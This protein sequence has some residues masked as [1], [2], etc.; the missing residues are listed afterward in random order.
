MEPILYH[1]S[2]PDLTGCKTVLNQRASSCDARQLVVA[3]AHEHSVVIPIL[4]TGVA[5][6][7]IPLQNGLLFY[8]L[9]HSGHERVK[10]RYSD[11]CDKSKPHLFFFTSSPPTSI[12]FSRSTSI[13]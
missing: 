1:L 5:V 7:I 11:L 12:T 4:L 6:G 10:L 13:F 3:V 2:Y 9:S 8:L